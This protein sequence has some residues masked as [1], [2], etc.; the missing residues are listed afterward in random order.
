MEFSQHWVHLIKT[1]NSKGLEGFPGLAVVK[2][3]PVSERCKKGRFDPWVGKIPSSRKWQV[4]TEFLP[5]KF[6][7]QRCLVGYCPWGHRELGMTEYTRTE[8][9]I[10]VCLNLNPDSFPP[11]YFLTSI[12]GNIYTNIYVL[13]LVTQSCLT[14]CDPM[15]CSLPGSS[16]HDDCLGKNTG[17]GYHARDQTQVFCIADGLFTLWA[18]EKA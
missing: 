14:L 13:C 12:T 16:V 18:T 10:Q 2:N 9:W 11:Q 6:H 15:D 17:V 3:L 1:A 7:G 4:T 8:C 5:G